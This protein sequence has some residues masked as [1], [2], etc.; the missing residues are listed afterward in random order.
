MAKATL[1]GIAPPAPYS[2]AYKMHGI[3][4]Y[5]VLLS[6]TGLSWDEEECAERQPYYDIS[7]IEVERR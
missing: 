4:P 5:A 1:Q 6:Q 3:L 2:A 7:N